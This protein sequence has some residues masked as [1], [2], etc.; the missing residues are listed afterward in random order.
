MA[1][2]AE[3]PHKTTRSTRAVTVTPPRKRKKCYSPSK[4]AKGGLLL[5]CY[6]YLC[7]RLLQRRAVR[8]LPATKNPPAVFSWPV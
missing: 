8:W 4:Q 5:G 7:I 6:M 1:K 2:N 3:K